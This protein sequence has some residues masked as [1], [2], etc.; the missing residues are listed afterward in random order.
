MGFCPLLLFPFVGDTGVEAHLPNP[1]INA[2]AVLER[3]VAFPQIDEYFLKQ[4]ADFIGI[5]R[6]HEAHRVDGAF[7]LPDHLRKCSIQCF[8]IELSSCFLSVRR[9]R[10]WKNYT[11]IELFGEEYEKVIKSNWPIVA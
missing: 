3:C 9:R 11:K 5:F 10:R 1:G 2:A 8:H 4:V 6:E 7:V